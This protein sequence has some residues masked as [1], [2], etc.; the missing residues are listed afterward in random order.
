MEYTIEVALEGRY[1]AV[2]T[3][4]CDDDTTGEGIAKVTLERVTVAGATI[5]GV[6]VWLIRNADTKT[7]PDYTTLSTA[8]ADA[9][10][11]PLRRT[12]GVEGA[13]A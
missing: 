13:G 6:R 5:T 7:T 8:A 4:H 1:P 12:V 2:E 9:P 11:V 3:G 10:V